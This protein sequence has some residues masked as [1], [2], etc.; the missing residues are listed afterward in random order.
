[1]ASIFYDEHLPDYTDLDNVTGIRPGFRFGD[2][3]WRL[4]VDL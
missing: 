2:Q 3:L 4:Q 1:M